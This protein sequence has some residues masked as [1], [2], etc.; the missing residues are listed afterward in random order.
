[1]TIKIT[2]IETYYDLGNKIFEYFMKEQIQAGNVITIDKGSGKVSKLARPK[3]YDATGALTR[4]VQCPE[5]ELQKRNRCN[6]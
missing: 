2:D 1:M 5:E 3:Y 6:L 4:F